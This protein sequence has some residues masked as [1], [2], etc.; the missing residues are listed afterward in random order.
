MK[1]IERQSETDGK[2]KD[3]LYDSFV[4]V[5]NS[6]KKGDESISPLD[7]ILKLRNKFPVY[8]EKDK[9]GLYIQHDVHEF[10]SSFMN[11]ISSVNSNFSKSTEIIIE[12][13]SVY[14]NL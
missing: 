5:L 1:L 8:A 6:L 4:N 11:Y 12:K 14:L 2:E 7:F 3:P 10:W 9:Y 13:K